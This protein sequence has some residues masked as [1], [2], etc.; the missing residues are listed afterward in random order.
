M[1]GPTVSP[2]RHLLIQALILIA[3]KYFNKSST[4]KKKHNVINI[5]PF[6]VVCKKDCIGIMVMMFAILPTYLHTQILLLKKQK[7]YY[8][9]KKT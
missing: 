3:S 5:S 9:K 7:K 4:K 6:V 1:P 2:H 8:F